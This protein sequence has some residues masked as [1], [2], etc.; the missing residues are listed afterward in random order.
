MPKGCD[1]EVY[2]KKLLSRLNVPEMR[3]M[4][5]VFAL[6]IVLCL[7]PMLESMI[8]KVTPESIPI[9]LI[10]SCSLFIALYVFIALVYGKRSYE[11]LRMAIFLAE[12][13]LFTFCATLV[14]L[15][16]SN[17]RSGK[18]ESSILEQCIE[19]LKYTV[20]FIGTAA[21][22]M[23]VFWVLSGRC[24][25]LNEWYE[26]KFP[27]TIAARK[28]A[29]FIT[30]INIIIAALLFI[31]HKVT[32]S[33]PGTTTIGNI[34]V[35]TVLMAVLIAETDFIYG[36]FFDTGLSLGKK[37][38]INVQRTKYAAF[39]IISIIVFLAAFV[40]CG[41]TGMPL[42]YGLS[43]LIWYYFCI[44][45]KNADSPLK[46]I[47]WFKP[48]KGKYIKLSTVVTFLFIGG[49]SLLLLYYFGLYRSGIVDEYDFHGLGSKL[50]R[51]K[52]DN[53][54][55][56]NAVLRIQSA[57][58]LYSLDYVSFGAGLTDCI[59]SNCTHF[60]GFI[61][62]AITMLLLTLSAFS[63]LAFIDKA[64][65]NR[66]NLS[67]MFCIAFSYIMLISFVNIFANLGIAPLVG[68][69]CFASGSGKT[70]YILCGLLLGAVL[71]PQTPS[72]N[73]GGN[74]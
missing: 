18:V 20:L 67:P 55:I 60:L 72:D 51:F 50:D 38:K 70:F 49:V 34:Q 26:K 24:R 66:R 12:F 35:G 4:F 61:W 64:V 62:L 2:M 33:V 52:C 19:T 32:S 42:F 28:K 9:F 45:V 30:I 48:K 27:R 57:G 56:Q 17:H 53:E 69:S 10:C 41:E 1:K 8:Y 31:G 73:K 43:F 23:L 3:M 16:M 5:L 68:V 37:S 14:T 25:K 46:H 11:E 58:I 15:P 22:S 7:G 29:I 54:Q 39:L 44:P 71:F 13:T 63:G 59:I 6:I 74:A 47:L 21:F 40:L 65:K 36:L